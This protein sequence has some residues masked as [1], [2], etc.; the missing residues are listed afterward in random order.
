MLRTL[1]VTL[2]FAAACSAADPPDGFV[3]LVGTDLTGWT[4]RT[5]DKADGSKTWAV[6]AG[7]LSCTGKPTGCLLTEKEYEN[8]TLRLEYR[9]LPTDLKRPNGGV[10]LHCQ[11]G[12]QCRYH[13]EK[14]SRPESA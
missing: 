5:K 3:P 6:K 12:D 2:L 10:L 9:Y 13:P 8:Y 4:V 14:T 1:A 7:V 11:K